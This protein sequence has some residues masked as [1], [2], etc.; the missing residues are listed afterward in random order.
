MSPQRHL[1]SFLLLLLTSPHQAI[2]VKNLPAGVDISEDTP[3]QVTI[4]GDPTGNTT[5]G[6]NLPISATIFWGVPGP[7]TC[8]GSVMVEFRLPQ[9]ADPD[10]GPTQEWC[11]T[12]PRVS[13]CGKFV[14]SKEAGCQARL[15]SEPGCQM[16]VNTA[17][18]IPEERAVG[19]RWWSVGVR[20]GVPAPAPE[21]ETLGLPPLAG[22]IRRPGGN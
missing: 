8:R 17:V 18:F 2:A 19:G 12:L 11:Y 21:S 20:C 10:A 14:A 9:P 4:N 15:F 13:G 1:L 16:Y 7:S 3:G 5:V 22:L 6:A